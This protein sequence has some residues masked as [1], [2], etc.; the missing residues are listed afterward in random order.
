[1][2]YRYILQLRL[3]RLRA[4]AFTKMCQKGQLMFV[5]FPELH[6]L[7]YFKFLSLE[8]LLNPW[9]LGPICFA[10]NLELFPT[11]DLKVKVK[12]NDFGKYGSL[13]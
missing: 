7:K 11:L 8:S 9:Y 2:L 10:Y 13:S 6:L 1:M 12:V 4:N 3:L 5:P